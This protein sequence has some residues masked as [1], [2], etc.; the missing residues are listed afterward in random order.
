MKIN[1]TE[2]EGL[3]FEISEKT[4]VEADGKEALFKEWIPKEMALIN[5][6]RGKTE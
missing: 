2:E 3:L 6:V 4:N 5:K 1:E